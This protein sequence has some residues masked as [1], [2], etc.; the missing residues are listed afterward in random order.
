MTSMPRSRAAA[1]H[2]R[3]PN[4]GV[5]ADDQCDAHGRR[6]LDHVGA[7][8]V[9]VLETMR[10]VKAGFAARHLDGFLQNDD[11]YG[12]VHVVIAVDQDFLLGLE[13]PLFMRANGVA[14]A[15]EQRRIVQVIESRE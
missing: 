3:G 14:H 5:D 12:S 15:G 10:N 7:H 4:A 6:A 2:F 13:W 11:G 1:H 9:T 8:A